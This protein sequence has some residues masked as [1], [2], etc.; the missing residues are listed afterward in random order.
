MC[1]LA[2]DGS[3]LALL[4]TTWHPDET[5]RSSRLIPDGNNASCRSHRRVDARLTQ[6]LDS[7]GMDF[8]PDVKEGAIT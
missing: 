1:I 8:V 2:I 4:N 3:Q 5:S 7:L 6:N